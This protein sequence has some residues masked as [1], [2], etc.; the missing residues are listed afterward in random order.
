MSIDELHDHMVGPLGSQVMLSLRRRD[1]SH[2]KISGSFRIKAE[3]TEDYYAVRLTRTLV[4]SQTTYVVPVALRC[5]YVEDER[6]DIEFKGED[7]S[8]KKSVDM[9]FKSLRQEIQSAG[10]TWQ[11][12]GVNF[13]SSM[14]CFVQMTAQPLICSCYGV[15]NDY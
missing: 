5:V 12:S 2:G 15:T 4:V 10:N 13:F 1:L 11:H 9:L 7:F 14:I 6:F 8:K 3:G